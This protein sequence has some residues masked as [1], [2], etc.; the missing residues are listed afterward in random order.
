MIKNKNLSFGSNEFARLLL[1]YNYQLKVGDVLAG[2]VIGIERQNALINIGTKAVGILPTKE[3]CINN[4]DSPIQVLFI[5]EFGEFLILKETKIIEKIIVSIKQL[6]NRRHWER[7]KQLDF[8]NIILYGYVKTTLKAGKILIFEDLKVF[9]PTS[10]IPKYFRRKI[11]QNKLLPFKLLEIKDKPLT[12]TGSIKLAFFKNQIT[13]LK[14]GMNCFGCVINI[15][16]FG[17][18]LNVKGIKCLLHISEI[19]SKKITDINK[20]YKKGDKLK[21]KV[22]YI[23]RN[24]GKISLSV[25]QLET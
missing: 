17:L 20:I 11:I 12:I 1:K 4:I 2:N 16:K 3:I 14:I 18:F 25:K 6:N 13:N 15:K 19:S 8:E 5:G 10:H 24:Q 9:I 23:D 7:I 21:I 22:I